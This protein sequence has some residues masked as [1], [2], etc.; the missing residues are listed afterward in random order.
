MAPCPASPNCVS[1]DST[2]PRHG[3]AP[4]SIKAGD[5]QAWERMRTAVSTLPR[6]RIVAEGDGYL[7]AECRSLLGFV[8][9]LELRLLPNE[10]TIAVR[11]AARLGYYDFGLNRRRVE[12][13]RQ[14]LGEK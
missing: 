14:R 7:R 3:I 6:T 13:L 5:A 11:S 4:L 9:D 2:D 1:S 12:R 8:D 10:R